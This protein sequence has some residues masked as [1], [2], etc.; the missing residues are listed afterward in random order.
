MG[1]TRFLVAGFLYL[2]GV[3]GV[4]LWKPALMFTEDG[5]WK[6]FGVGRSP[7]THTWMPFWLFAIL[8]AMISYIVASLFLIGLGYTPVKGK[9][10]NMDINT[11]LSLPSPEELVENSIQKGKLPKGYYILNTMAPESGGVPSYIYLGKA[12]PTD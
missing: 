1:L 2:C 3:A 9:R 7:K 5:I 4:L 10:G 12:L 8:W 6:E 11:P